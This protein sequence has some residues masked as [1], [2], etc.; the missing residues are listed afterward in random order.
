MAHWDST[1]HLLQYGAAVGSRLALCGATNVRCTMLTKR[2]TCEK[3]Q[4]LMNEESR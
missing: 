1:V 4:K 2:V 3:C